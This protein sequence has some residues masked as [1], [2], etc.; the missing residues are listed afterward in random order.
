[1]YQYNSWLRFDFN[2]AYT[3][4]RFTDSDPAGDHIPGAA[5]M[6]A[7]GGATFGPALGWFGAVKVRHFGTRPLIEDDSVRSGSTTL[8]NARLGYRWEGGMRLSLDVINLFNAKTNQI[9]YYYDSRVT[10]K[11]P[12]TADRHIHPVEPLAVRV[13]L[14]REF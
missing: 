11:T 14:A 10:R 3:H 6:V 13:S 4:A 1:M 12:V 9:A 5:T 7:T 2:F 8:V